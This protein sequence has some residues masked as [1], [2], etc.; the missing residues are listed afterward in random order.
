MEKVGGRR[1]VFEL[2][3]NSCSGM[4]DVRRSLLSQKKVE[5]FHKCRASVLN[6]FSFDM[7]RLPAIQRVTKESLYA[8]KTVKNVC[9]VR[10]KFEQLCDAKLGMSYVMDLFPRHNV[11]Q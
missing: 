9:L 7:L 2:L 3:S 10:Y 11:Q 6:I 4:R 1:P 5:W 8:S